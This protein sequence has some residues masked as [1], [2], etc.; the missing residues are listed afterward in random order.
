MNRSVTSYCHES[1]VTGSTCLTAYGDGVIRP[2]GKH[3]LVRNTG[4]FQH[5]CGLFPYRTC[6]PGSG[7]HIHHNQ[8]YTFFV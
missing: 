5:Y 8:P 3:G 7:K 4:I 6:L 1:A 2:T